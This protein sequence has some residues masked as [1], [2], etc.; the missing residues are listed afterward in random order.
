VAFVFSRHRAGIFGAAR[1][2]LARLPGLRR[3]AGVLGR[4][5]EVLAQL[6]EQIVGFY[7]RSPGR[8]CAALLIDFSGRTIGTLEY[9]LIARSLGVPIGLVTAFV[10]GSLL[11]LG[12]NILFFMPFDVGSREGGAGLL[13]G[14]L[15]LPSSL[16]IYAG[17]V[18]RL[19]WAVWVAIG[20]ALIWVARR[21]APVRVA[22][23]EG[24]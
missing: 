1:S 12:L 4:H 6:D 14:L 11:V 22:A 7:E 21:P 20:L 15:G 10:M 8:F 16:G 17:V 24:A 9:Y 18:T 23:A 5:G 3:L 2:T 13:F 19:R